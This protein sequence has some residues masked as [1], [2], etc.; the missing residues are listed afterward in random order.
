MRGSGW[1]GG[2][3]CE[4]IRSK[5][6]FLLP[7]ELAPCEHLLCH[8]CIEVLAPFE[9][10]LELPHAPAAEPF[11]ARAW[12]APSIEKRAQCHRGKATAQ[13]AV[14]LLVVGVGG[15]RWLAQIDSCVPRDRVQDAVAVFGLR[16]FGLLHLRVQGAHRELER[17]VPARMESRG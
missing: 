3:I 12:G 6:L 16:R 1:L 8:S 14:E 5:T 10:E 7:R 15:V 9:V 4:K 11:K 2:S 13:E 17:K